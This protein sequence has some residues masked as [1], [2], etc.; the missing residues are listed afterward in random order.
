[1]KGDRKFNLKKKR[2]YF[3]NGERHGQGYY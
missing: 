1:M 2:P 3:G